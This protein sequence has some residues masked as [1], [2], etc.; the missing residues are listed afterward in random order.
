MGEHS[1]E[2]GIS[3][4]EALGPA[5]EHTSPIVWSAGPVRHVVACRVLLQV[6]EGTHNLIDVNLP[7]DV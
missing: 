7:V 2:S 6:S 4:Q 3:E 5:V 1:T